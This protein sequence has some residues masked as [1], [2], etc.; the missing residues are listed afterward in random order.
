MI[1]PAT[2]GWSHHVSVC[3]TLT[4]TTMSSKSE[5]RQRKRTRRTQIIDES[6]EDPIATGSSTGIV[7][8][9]ESGQYT[10]GRYFLHPSI[11]HH[12]DWDIGDEWAEDDTEFS[13]DDSGNAYLAE[14]DN[15]GYTHHIVP[16]VSKKRKRKQN[17]RSKISVGLFAYFILV[18]SLILYS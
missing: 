10:G 12:S 7:G 3:V 13:L 16:D 2:Y 1:V 8:H 5:S 9:Q 17:P 11:Q 15:D 6:Y 4:S 14:L 18:L